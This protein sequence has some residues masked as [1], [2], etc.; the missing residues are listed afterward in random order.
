MDNSF[1]IKFGADTS[2][3]EKGVEDAK[4]AVKDL[5]ENIEDIGKS[6]KKTSNGFS[7]LFKEGNKGFEAL[8]SITGGYAEEILDLGSSLASA[9]K[10]GVV[11]ARAL[12]VALVATGIGAFIVLLGLVIAYWGEI[13]GFV[14]G[15]SKE[16]GDQLEVLQDQGEEQQ[17]IV[18]LLNA[19]D[20]ILKLQGKSQLQINNLKIKELTTL[21]EIK[22]A[23]LGNLK[24]QLE[25]AKTQEKVYRDLAVKLVAFAIAPI[26]GIALAIDN[27]TG[28]ATNLADKVDELAVSFT[29]LVTPDLTTDLTDEFKALELETT[30]L[31]NTIAGLE[32]ANIELNIDRPKDLEPIEYTAFKSSIGEIVNLLDTD[33]I[34]KGMDNFGAEIAGKLAKGTEAVKIKEAEMKIALEN[35]NTN[36]RALI[37][38]GIA[39]T[40]GEVGVALGTAL[41]EG[42]NVIDAIGSALLQGV[43]GV[44]SGFADLLIQ[45]GTTALLYSFLKKAITSDPTGAAAIAAAPG[46]IAAG[47]A[48][49]VI[50]GAISGS[51]GGGSGGGSGGGGGASSSSGGGRGSGGSVN[52]G[53]GGSSGGFGS[54]VF[55]I[56][57]TKLVGVLSKTLKE[58]SALS[59]KLNVTG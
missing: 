25:G 21:F 42:T 55:E 56:A 39:S 47:I 15:V 45:F 7:D 10:A 28:G 26:K 36:A 40:L 51:M 33:F 30:K 50:S 11:G 38:D 17:Y 3:L 49:K 43:A 46:L 23:Q 37:V 41:A 5:D 16:L 4:D 12:T 58:N 8:D 54:V 14:T 22:K 44:M 48:L 35:L 9:F 19:S 53:S 57:G 18:D 1:D 13:K 52:Y 32:L 24:Q 20:K 29:K 2:G 27:L 31:E 59:G 6:V 34:T